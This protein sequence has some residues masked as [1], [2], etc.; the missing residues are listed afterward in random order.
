MGVS[1]VGQE[2]IEGALA[3]E[4]QCL[5]VAAAAIDVVPA[6]L[7]AVEGRPDG[8]V[9]ADDQSSAHRTLLP[10][11]AGC[12]ASIGLRTSFAQYTSLNKIVRSQ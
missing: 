5:H 6:E 10:S 8:P 3:N 2:D 7:A 9:V 1:A 4:L 11:N 12:S